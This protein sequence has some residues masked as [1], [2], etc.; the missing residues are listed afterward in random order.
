M[1]LLAAMLVI[2]GFFEHPLKVSGVVRD[3]DGDDPL[4][5]GAASAMGRDD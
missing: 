2:I 1:C 3:E 4:V 5:V